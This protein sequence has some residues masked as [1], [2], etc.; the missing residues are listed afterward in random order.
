L[1]ED[2]LVLFLGQAYDT[3][4]EILIIPLSTVV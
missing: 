1:E 3:R 4:S 2:N